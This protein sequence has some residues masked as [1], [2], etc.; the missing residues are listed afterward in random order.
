MNNKSEIIA[1]QLLIEIKTEHSKLVYSELKNL[2][3][4]KKWLLLKRVFFA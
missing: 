3:Q 1:K 4:T 2:V